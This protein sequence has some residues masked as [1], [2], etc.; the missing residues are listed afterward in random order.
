MPIKPFN[1]IHTS[2]SWLVVICLF[3]VVLMMAWLL[4]DSAQQDEARLT[5]DVLVD[6][7]TLSAIVDGAFT[8]AEQAMFAL[9]SSPLAH[10]A[11]LSGF[12]HQSKAVSQSLG[13]EAIAVIDTQFNP[14]MHT[15]YPFGQVLPR[16]AS[17]THLE[18]VLKTGKPVVSGIF[19]D[20]AVKN[21]VV[22][23]AVPI[24]D[25]GSVSR[26]LVGALPADRVQ[27]ILEKYKLTSGQT[28]GIFDRTDV[29]VALIGADVTIDQER[30]KKIHLGLSNAL[31]TSG[32]GTV[33]TLN[34][35]GQ[36]VLNTYSRSATSRWGVAIAMTRQSLTADLWRSLWHLIL[37]S[38]LIVGASLA[39]AWVMGGKIAG[40]VQ[41]LR[42]L[43]HKLGA[44]EPLVMPARP[45]VV[46]EVQ[47]AAQA[48]VEASQALVD[49]NASLVISEARV[50]S[51]LE[52]AMDAIITVDATHRIVLF[53]RAA[54]NMFRYKAEQAM[55]L[56]M[57]DLLIDWSDNVLDSV[58][59]ATGL[60]LGGES[61]PAELT[62]SVA[63]EADLQLFTFI[64]RDVS[65]QVRARNALERSNHDLKQF[66]FV[67]S[68]DLKTPLRSIGGFV[69]ML[70]KSHAGVFDANANA[71]VER[72]LNA[73]KRLE[74]L[75]ED[76]L[77]YA[78]IDVVA[79]APSLVDMS[80]VAHEVVSLLDAS[81]AQT[82]GTVTVDKLPVVM[83]NRTQLVQ[84][85]LNLIGNGLKYCRGHA[86]VVHLGAVW[87]DGT[88]VFSVTDNG[89]GI[90]AEHHEKVFEVFKR[91]HSQSEFA[92]TGIGLA[93]CKRIVDAHGGRVWVTSEPDSGSTFS[94]T[95]KS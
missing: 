12:Y 92:G 49:S 14:L 40:S 23:I 94:F 13:F 37:A 56:P 6:A 75:T 89:I 47:M 7:R 29:V 3:P 59:I 46:P 83:G 32:E 26:V 64:I 38:L 22:Q 48:L 68:H 93:V 4:W 1:S 85:L 72:T 5:Q 62:I 90:D 76:L 87:Q 18:E 20:G 57:Q 45:L 17:L 79:L 34:L 50:R 42:A 30:G 33:E 53:N 8:A 81:I 19:M 78:Q 15:S 31:S 65:D 73:V 63:Q 70:A 82:T 91:L 28:V 51:I 60:R 36:K 25:E 67:A 77:R 71:L 39:I 55:G 84:L 95:L 9:A 41:T 24:L 66:A 74:H 43:A 16:P 44:G 11:D 35:Q 10:T 58:G 52:S 27:K 80:D 2:L 88:W 86:P 21:Y 69:Q 54:S 61:F